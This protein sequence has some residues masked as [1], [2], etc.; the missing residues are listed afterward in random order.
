MEKCILTAVLPSG[1]NMLIQIDVSSDFVIA[2]SWMMGDTVNLKLG[3]LCELT[4]TYSFK[5]N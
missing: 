1:Q 5:K 4:D 3:G 2:V